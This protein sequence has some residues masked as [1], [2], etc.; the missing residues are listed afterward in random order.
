MAMNGIIKINC[1]KVYDNGMSYLSYC[2]EIKRIK[3]ELETI[4]SDIQNAWNGADSHNFMVSFESHISN[5]DFLTSFL[6]ANGEL[7]KKNA[8]DH[9]GIDTRFASSME[10][11]DINDF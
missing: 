11:S 8:L 4:S 10:R 6:D 7:L 9:S 1:R 5:I 3:S 2:N